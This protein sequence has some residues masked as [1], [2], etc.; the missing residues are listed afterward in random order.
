MRIAYIAADPG[1][2]VLGTKGC[3]IHVQEVLRAMVKR[4]V[5]IDLF[6][7]SLSRDKTQEASADPQA[8]L[9]QFPGLEQIR[10]HPL[11]AAPRGDLAFREQQCLA[12][13]GPLRF[14]LQAQG[15]FSL[16][17]ERYS[18]W[19]FAGMEYACSNGTPG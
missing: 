13:N 5:Q 18:L 6:A 12:A 14:A 10:L 2:P 1:V 15:G 7:T 11:P 4:D 3:S 16:I 17:Y 8:R 19:S 9:A